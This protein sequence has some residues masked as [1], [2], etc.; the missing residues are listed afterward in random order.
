MADPT[1][2]QEPPG[3]APAPA[4]P[5]A[6]AAGVAQSGA[7]AEPPV[8]GT[9]P[10]KTIAIGA[11][12]VLLLCVAVCLGVQFYP[13]L[14]ET[15]SAPQLMGQAAPDFALS[16]LDGQQVTLSALRGIPVALNFWATWCPS[17]VT[18]LPDL[19]RAAAEHAGEIH[20]YAVSLDAN[21]ADIP[22][23]LAAHGVDLPVLLDTDGD[24]AAKYRVRGIPLTVFIDASG[25]IA[26][27]HIGPLSADKFGD[28]VRQVVAGSK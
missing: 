16:T 13:L 1:A 3:D 22:P 4:R 18:E 26:A 12:V 20:F 11:G 9:K 6:A 19:Q 27:R 7:L 17:C 21:P 10:I 2:R 25:K 28:Y 14:V 8:G 5:G 24:A 15:V 23:F